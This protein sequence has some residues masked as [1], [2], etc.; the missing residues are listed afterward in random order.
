[1][2]ETSLLTKRAELVYVAPCPPTRTDRA[3]RVHVFR[4]VP[5]MGPARPHAKARA[6]LGEPD[7][8]LLAMPPDQTTEIEQGC[9]VQWMLCA[10][11]LEVCPF[12][13]FYR[14]MFDAGVDASPTF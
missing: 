11:F 3:A 1:L 12:S 9:P 4:V 8:S 14:R 13:V 7:D 10:H 2:E 6:L 5:R